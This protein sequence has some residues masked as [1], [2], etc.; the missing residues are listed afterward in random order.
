MYYRLLQTAN[1]GSDNGLVPNRWQAII[2]TNDGPIYCHIYVS[3]GLYELTHI[4]WDKMADIL[5][6]IFWNVFFKEHFNILIKISLKLV[7]TGAGKNKLALFK[8]TTWHRTGHSPHQ[9]LK[10]QL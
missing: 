9:A 3:L 6:M 7:L 1:S 4:G 8:V 10:S 2:W 5:R